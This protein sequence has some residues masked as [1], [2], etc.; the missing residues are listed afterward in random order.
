MSENWRSTSRTPARAT[1]S[2]TSSLEGAVTS[3]P[4]LARFA[5]FV[6]FSNWGSPALLI[7]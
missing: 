2:N 4:V 7:L 1:R 6:S 5:T 3:V